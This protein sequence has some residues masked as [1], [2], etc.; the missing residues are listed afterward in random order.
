MKQIFDPQIPNRNVFEWKKHIS[1][2]RWARNTYGRRIRLFVI[3]YRTH[4]T[5]TRDK[6]HS[7]KAYAMI[8]TAAAFI[9]G[10]FIYF[11]VRLLD[12]SIQL[13]YKQ[14]HWDRSPRTILNAKI[15]IH[16]ACA[17][18]KNQLRDHQSTHI[19]N[20]FVFKSQ[21]CCCFFFCGI[22]FVYFIGL[23]LLITV[24]DLHLLN[25]LSAAIKYRVSHG[26]IANGSS[27][28]RMLRF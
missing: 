28:W 10:R 20:K 6:C 27:V 21:A 2:R 19:F 12:L 14:N 26:L 8:L 5:M 17:G 25:S 16:V 18:Q 7:V 1:N 13:E 11:C 23:A 22:W 15:L 4:C 3:A 24:G 9:R